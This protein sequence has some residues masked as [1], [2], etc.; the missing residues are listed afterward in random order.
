MKYTLI[1]IYLLMRSDP[2]SVMVRNFFKLEAVRKLKIS[3]SQVIYIIRRNLK[4]KLIFS[5]KNNRQ[6]LL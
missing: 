2:I 5:A 1:V 6:F 3:Q 4:L